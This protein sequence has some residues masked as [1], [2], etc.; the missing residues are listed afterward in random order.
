MVLAKSL[1]MLWPD[2]DILMVW[3]HLIPQPEHCVVRKNG[4]IIDGDR[5]CREADFLR[6]YAKEEIGL[7]EDN[8]SLEPFDEEACEEEDFCNIF[9]AQL[10]DYILDT[11]QTMTRGIAA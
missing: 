9:N 4:F 11:Y 3:N 5:S 6:R 10:A 7:F 8:M 1:K 2:S